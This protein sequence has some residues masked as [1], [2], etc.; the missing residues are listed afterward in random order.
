MGFVGT[1]ALS[2]AVV[3][4]LQSLPGQR[5]PIL[6]SPRS[7]AI[8]TAL[9]AAYPLVTRAESNQE[10]VDGSDIV[11]LAV[12]PRQLREVATSLRFRPEQTVIS[13]VAGVMLAELADYVA[14]ARTIC[15]AIPLPPIRFKRGPILLYP[16][17]EPALS[18]MAPLGD[19]VPLDS[20]A[21]M[22]K[23]TSATALMSSFFEAQN[24]VVHWLRTQGLE[25]GTTTSFV[26]SLFDGLSTLAQH[27]EQA[28]HPL[29]P[30]EHETKGGL[31]ESVRRYLLD[32]GWFAELQAALDHVARHRLT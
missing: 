13:L 19:V 8:S 3:K 26:R 27:E 6:L 18:V 9:A 5:Q 20:E 30:A 4:G 11:F 22:V 28:G 1:G 10:V 24:T 31:N 23:L 16:Q 12:L 32:K 7:A 17:I 25:E 21:A 29:I 2:E 14:P 15:R